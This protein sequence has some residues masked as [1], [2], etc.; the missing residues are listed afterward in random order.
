MGR[1]CGVGGCCLD[2]RI[3]LGLPFN[4]FGLFRGLRRVTLVSGL[5]RYNHRLDLI[6]QRVKRFQRLRPRCRVLASGPLHVLRGRRAAFSTGQDRL[7][8]PDTSVESVGIP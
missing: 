6:D 5:Q 4:R 1:S 3:L 7:V 2:A 8:S